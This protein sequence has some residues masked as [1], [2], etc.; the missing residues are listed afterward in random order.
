MFTNH[1]EGRSALLNYFRLFDA[2]KYIEYNQI[3][4][5]DV[6]ATFIEYLKNAYA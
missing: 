1:R 3:Y 5:K 4:L 6:E 2:K